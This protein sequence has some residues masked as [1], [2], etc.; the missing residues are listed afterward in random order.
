VRVILEVCQTA[1]GLS[2]KRVQIKQ[3]SRHDLL[4]V[5]YAHTPF[6]LL[7]VHYHHHRW[8][9]LW[10]SMATF[11][12]ECR[13]LQ[14]HKGRAPLQE[15]QGCGWLGLERQCWSCC[16]LKSNSEREVYK[17]VATGLRVMH[18]AGGQAM[19][20]TPTPLTRHHTSCRWHVTCQR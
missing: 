6:T 15:Q 1:C 5:Q 11:K 20:A 14:Q 18:Q 17:W 13:V 19:A 10:V 4:H 2:F 7:C 12:S 16:S 9:A 3:A 8:R